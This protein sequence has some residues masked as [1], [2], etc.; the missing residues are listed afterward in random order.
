MKKIDTPCP[1]CG[2]EECVGEAKGTWYSP[3]PADDCPSN[4]GMGCCPKCGSK[5]LRWHIVNADAWIDDIPFPPI[6]IEFRCE[7]CDPDPLCSEV[8]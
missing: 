1:D 3:C 4:S 6:S 7:N 8:L 2:R 5:E